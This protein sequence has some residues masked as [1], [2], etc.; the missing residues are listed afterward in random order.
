MIMAL[1]ASAPA[2]AQSANDPADPSKFGDWQVVCDDGGCRLAQSIVT[3]ETGAALLLVRI[4]AG[5]PPTAILTAPLGVFLKTGLIVKVDRNRARAYAFEICDDL[6][7]HAG[8]T[9]DADLVREFQR[10]LT[11]EITFFDGNQNKV[12]LPVSLVGFTDGFN[13]VSEARE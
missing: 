7:C 6:G 2:L 8:V 11:A 3:A 13:A 5:D 9:L 12:S 4:F 10:G 1:M